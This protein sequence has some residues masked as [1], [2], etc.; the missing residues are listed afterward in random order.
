MKATNKKSQARCPQKQVFL[1]SVGFSFETYSSAFWL[2]T[3]QIMILLMAY[4]R[5]FAL[6]PIFLIHPVLEFRGS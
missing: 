6:V 1:K 2:V 5:P 4:A 3:S